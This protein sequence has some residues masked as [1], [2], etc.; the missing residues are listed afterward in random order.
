[1]PERLRQDPSAPMGTGPY[2]REPGMTD[3]RR[4]SNLN[5]VRRRVHRRVIQVSPRTFHLLVNAWGL[6]IGALSVFA[7]VLF[8]TVPEFALQQTSVGQQLGALDMV[9]NALY[10]IA[11]ALIVYGLVADRRGA[12][13][14]GLV[15]L[16]TT[17]LINFLAIVIT[18]GPRAL[19]VVPQL[20]GVTAAALAR[21]LIVSQVIH[22][23][24]GRRE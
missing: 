7:S 2:G 23:R 3:R 24:V 5:R 10:G 21:A 22:V 12:D 9:W 11:G 19:V 4:D 14:F 18:L 8:F 1:M 17:T 15:L 20:I 13:A 6:V 16:A